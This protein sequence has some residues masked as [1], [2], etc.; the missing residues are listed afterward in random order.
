MPEQ[1]PSDRTRTLADYVVLFIRYGVGSILIV[2]GFVLLITSP[3]GFGVDGFALL[4]GAGGSI[5]A[6][7][8]LFRLGVSG[9]EERRREEEARVYLAEHGHWPDEPR[10]EPASPQ[11]EP[12]PPEAEPAAAADEHH[13]AGRGQHGDH[14]G[15][16]TGFSR[17]LGSRH[18]RRGPG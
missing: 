5:L 6:L 10:P 4:A 15:R 7:N 2:A 1:T 3:G 12:A 16:R 18:R 14:A 13:D 17:E 9:D 8:F 11:P